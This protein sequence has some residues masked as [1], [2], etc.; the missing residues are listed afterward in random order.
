[1]SPHRRSAP[2]RRPPPQ[3]GARRDAFLPAPLGLSS[4][5][6]YEG[7]C[8]LSRGPAPVVNERVGQAIRGETS[9]LEAFA[10]YSAGPSTPARARVS[11]DS[12]ITSRRLPIR[13]DARWPAL[14]SSYVFE[15]PIPRRRAV[16]GM[17]SRSGRTASRALP[18]SRMVVPCV[19]LNGCHA[20]RATSDRPYAGTYAMLTKILRQPTVKAGVTPPA[21]SAGR[22]AK[23]PVTPVVGGYI[24]AP[25]QRAAPIYARPP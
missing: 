2:G 11:V 12:T 5:G 10:D 8:T 15:R 21:V 17:D 9:G 1:M 6:A 3:L 19:R 22:A 13:T 14:I 23:P 25:H 7:A 4:G 20:P 16:A 18:M 24:L